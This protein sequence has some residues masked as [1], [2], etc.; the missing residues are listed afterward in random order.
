MKATSRFDIA[1]EKLYNAFHNDTLHPECCN[2]CAVGNILDHKDFWKNFS[3]QHG[4]LQLNYLG[5][6]HESLG[7]KFNGYFPSELLLI[8]YTF[9]HA[10]GYQ[11]PLHY[12]HKKPD[13]PKDKD[14]LFNG[15]SA[16]VS[17]LCKLDNITDIM[18]CSSLFHYKKEAVPKSNAPA[19][20]LT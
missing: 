18:D 12:K 13:D 17:L 15:L 8:E 19:L 6:V 2:Q 14:I 9:L 3:D 10:C 20:Q 4:S 16:V 5:K 11:L 7:R 1:V